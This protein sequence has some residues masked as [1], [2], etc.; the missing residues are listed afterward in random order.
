[1]LT[2]L[3]R[4]NL[5]VT[6]KLFSNKIIFRMRPCQTHTKSAEVREGRGSYACFLITQPFL[7]IYRHTI[8]QIKAEYHS[9]LLYNSS[10][11]EKCKGNRIFF[12]QF[13]FS[14]TD[15]SFTTQNNFQQF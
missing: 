15:F 3:K 10:K 5:K 8:H 12:F 4:Q 7:K 6:K 2:C 9:Y 13:Y 1:M 14:D 11:S